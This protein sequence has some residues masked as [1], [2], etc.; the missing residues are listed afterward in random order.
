MRLVLHLLR[1]EES[2]VNEF[3]QALLRLKTDLKECREC[4][5]ASDDHLCMICQDRH[6]NRAQICVVQDIQDVMAI[7]NTMQYR[8][9]YHVLG[10]LI[11]P[12]DGIGPD[13]IKI[14]DL[15]RRVS[16]ETPEEVIFALSANM[17]GDT[18]AFYISRQLKDINIRVSVLSR[19]ISVGG[20]LEYA[21]EITLGRSIHLR[22]PYQ[23]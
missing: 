8:G 9:L 22:T 7:E 10:G 14:E 2:D 6:R 16:I 18:T 1:Q 21:D 19:G 23:A 20:Q 5:M 13:Q 12:M 17:E 4:H 11:S 3:S 15:L